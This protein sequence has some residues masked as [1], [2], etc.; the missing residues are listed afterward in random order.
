MA[1][2]NS[3]GCDVVE[4]REHGR[5]RVVD[6]DV[7]RPEM[8]LD[9]RRGARTCS[10]LG[11]RQQRGRKGCRRARRTSAAA[12]SRPA[13]PRAIK[14]TAAPCLRELARDRAADAARGAGD[15]DY[16]AL[17]H[18]AT[19]ADRR[20]TRPSP[21]SLL[22]AARAQD[23]R[24]MGGQRH[25]LSQLRSPSGGPRSRPTRICEPSSARPAVAPRHTSAAGLTTDNS[26]S[27]HGRHAVTWM[28]SGV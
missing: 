10:K 6:P 8:I 13:R 15:D 17:S 24:R 14:P 1:R 21:R 28:R 3:L 25:Q 18:F 2:S 19:P 7:D 22:V 12:P 5:H 27:S 11:S 16:L 23:R 9:G 4:E 20:R 26:A